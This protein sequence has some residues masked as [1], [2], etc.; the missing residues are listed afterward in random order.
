MKCNAST[1]FFAER[2]L[3][4]REERST[5]DV[6][7]IWESVMRACWQ[8]LYGFDNPKKRTN[9]NKFWEAWLEAVSPESN[10]DILN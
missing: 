5:C 4:F 7:S 2:L 9:S 8:L 10:F 3:I 6:A 1:Y